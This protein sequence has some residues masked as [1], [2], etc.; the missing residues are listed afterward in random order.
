MNGFTWIGLFVLA[1]AGIAFLT[2]LL[3]LVIDG[4]FFDESGDKFWLSAWIASIIGSAIA[5][6]SFV[7][8]HQ[9]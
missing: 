7:L 2:C 1:L 8:L 3:G 9:T 6:A 5:V 4:L